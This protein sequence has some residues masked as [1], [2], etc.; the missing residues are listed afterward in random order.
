MTFEL[1]NHELHSQS[2]ADILRTISVPGIPTPIACCVPVVFTDRGCVML[3][4]AQEQEG[5][6]RATSEIHLALVVVDRST[7]VGTM[8]VLFFEIRLAP[9][10]KVTPKL[11]SAQATEAAFAP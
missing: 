4:C 11:D 10:P 6:I 5:L 8:Y 2:P 9:N 7:G 1:S 3:V